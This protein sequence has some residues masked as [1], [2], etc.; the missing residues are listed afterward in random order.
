V[1]IHRINGL[2]PVMHEKHLPTTI[3]FTQDRL[4]YVSWENKAQCE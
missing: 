2:N 4:T 3:Q 1:L